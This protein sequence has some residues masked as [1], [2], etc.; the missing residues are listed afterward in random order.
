MP[1]TVWI[2]AIGRARSVV[3]LAVMAVAACGPAV[4]ESATGEVTD[5]STTTGDLGQFTT[6]GN[7]PSC[8]DGV[9]SLDEACFE[10]HVVPF[11]AGA[12][13]VGDFD[14][15][16]L[17]DHASN[18]NVVY[19]HVGPAWE[20]SSLDSTDFPGP[21][22]ADDFDGDRIADLVVAARGARELLV[23]EGSAGDGLMP[24]GSI[25]IGLEV[26][27]LEIADVG[28]DGAPDILVGER[29]DPFSVQVIENDGNGNFTAGEINTYPGLG[30]PRMSAGDMDGDGVAD[31]F[32]GH[33]WELQGVV[34]F[35]RPNGGFDSELL[36]VD[37]EA[38]TADW[39]D[40]N[41]DNFDDLLSLNNS[42][43]ALRLSSGRSFVSPITT[44]IAE[45]DY[46]PEV[47]AI[48]RSPGA[49][50]ND[51]YVAIHQV[52]V[53]LAPLRELR[54]HR[55]AA[56]NADGFAASPSVVIHTGCTTLQAVSD[57]K[58]LNLNGDSF[59]DLALWFNVA[60]GQ[61][62]AAYNIYLVADP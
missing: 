11:A 9:L 30:V 52:S 20:S 19:T 26:H 38:A 56:P 16:G 36:E 48:D 29:R 49:G 22:V 33:I 40:V 24:T 25:P 46:P 37:I 50:T 15:N 1:S 3:V 17:D 5:T 59:T 43:V 18:Q 28:G 10:V 53:E 58:T 21:A 13:A 35:G 60:C 27:D 62:L 54:I 14:G 32:F 47:M 31:L 41:G 23:Y 12:E 6:T 42:N 39:L 55:L 2:L 8:G 34:L 61:Q 44:L 7:S 4:G 51:V 57:L 45:P